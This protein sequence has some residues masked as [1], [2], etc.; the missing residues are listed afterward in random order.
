MIDIN[1]VKKLAELA[2]IEMTDE[3]IANFTK[4]IDPIL[5]YVVQIQQ[6]TGSNATRTIPE[7]RNITRP[8]ENPNESFSNTEKIVAEFPRKE[9]N[10]LKVK[11][12]L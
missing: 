10:L 5:G 2:R 6:V 12:I 3:E 9:G 7:H 8:D 1:E 11:K 4:E